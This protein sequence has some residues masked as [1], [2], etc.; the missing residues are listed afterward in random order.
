MLLHHEINNTLYKIFFY[1]SIKLSTIPPL[2]KSIRQWLQFSWFPERATTSSKI[3]SGT[4]LGLR[5]NYTNITS[6]YDLLLIYIVP[7]NNVKH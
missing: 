1:C 2:M 4:K 6:S 5:S 3:S 7:L